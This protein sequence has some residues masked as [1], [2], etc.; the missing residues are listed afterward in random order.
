M[1]E[2]SKELLVNKFNMILDNQGRLM[3]NDQKKSFNQ[4]NHRDLLGLFTNS[5]PEVFCKKG[6]LKKFTNFT[7]KY[8]CCSLF[9]TKLQ[10]IR[11]A[12]FKDIYFEE[13]LRKTA[14]ICFTSKYYSK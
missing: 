11:K 2:I 12:Y 6:V 5:H 14:S 1:N 8:L 3:L 4:M 9:L 13:H 10:V 7:G